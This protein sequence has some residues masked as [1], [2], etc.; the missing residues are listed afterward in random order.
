MSRTRQLMFTAICLASAVWSFAVLFP[1]YVRFEYSGVV[2]GIRSG[3]TEKNP[4]FIETAL[5]HLEGARR[6]TYCNL[7]LEEDYQL[8]RA[9]MADQALNADNDTQTDQALLRMQTALEDYLACNP[10]DGKGW[11]D[12]SAVVTIREGFSPA[13]LADYKMSAYVS[14]G[15]SWLAQKRLAMALR[16]RPMLDQEALEISRADLAVLERAHP[17]KMTAIKTMAGV[18]SAEALRAIFA[19]Q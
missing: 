14:P 17:N 15:E 16:V 13:A 4:N 9:H 8:L 12:L 6:F 18:D 11:L 10:R 19:P 2:D 1:A 7:D 5:I 3:K